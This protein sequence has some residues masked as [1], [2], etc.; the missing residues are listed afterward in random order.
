MNIGISAKPETLYRARFLAALNAASCD[1]ILCPPHALAALIHGA[2]TQ[3]PLAASYS[4]IYNLLHMPGG[5]VPVTRV[6]HDEESDRP[7]SRDRVEAMAR[8]SEQ[9]SAGLPLGV[10]IVGRHWREDVALALMAAVEAGV[11]ANT[12]YPAMPPI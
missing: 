10:Q 1:A 3:V 4:M 6:R 2:T 12:G 8:R 7:A 5:V 9:N 11:R